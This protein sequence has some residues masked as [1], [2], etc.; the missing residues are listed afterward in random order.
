MTLHMRRV[1]K[2]GQRRLSCKKD[3]CFLSY[4]IDIRSAVVH[5]G[6]PN[7]RS[8]ID[9]VLLDSIEEP[10]ER[11]PK[12]RASCKSALFSSKALSNSLSLALN[13]A[14]EEEEACAARTPLA[15]RFRQAMT[16]NG[17]AR[18]FQGP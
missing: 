9:F 16:L 8:V 1:T 6:S 11:L 4:E 2:L 10:E 5:G 14:A 15:S 17:C 3:A 7:L 18:A 13:A 12:E